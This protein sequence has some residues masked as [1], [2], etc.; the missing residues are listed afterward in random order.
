MNFQI[1]YHKM[2][3]VSDFGVKLGKKTVA[4]DKLKKVVFPVISIENNSCSQLKYHRINNNIL[5]MQHQSQ[6]QPLVTDTAGF[7][8]SE[9]GEDWIIL[10][11][12][13]RSS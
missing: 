7:G 4:S 10:I 1:L 3:T 9:I 2:N 5:K 8:E 12:V 6:L 13:Q 11:K